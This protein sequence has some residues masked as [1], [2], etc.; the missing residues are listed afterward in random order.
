LEIIIFVILNREAIAMLGFIFILL[1]LLGIWAFMLASSNIQEIKEHWNE[2]RCKMGVM[3][4][5][6]FY[7]HNT[8]EN[9]NYC[10]KNIFT[11]ESGPLLS[12][13]LQILAT[14]IGTISIFVSTLNS[15]RVQFATLLGGINTIFQNFSDRMKQLTYHI[16]V[17]AMRM[18][19]LMKRLYGTFNAMMFMTISGITAMTNF[20]DTFL[21]K[22][23]DT[24]CF[25]PDTPIYVEGKGEIPISEVKMGDTLEGGGKVTSLFRFHA[26]G[27][28]MVILNNILVSTNH[29]V[30]DGTHWVKAE[31][32][33]DA[34][35]AAPWAGGNERPL[36]CLNTSDHRIPLGGYVFLDYD[37][38]EE[39]DQTTMAWIE[40]VINGT[41]STGEVNNISY[42]NS[43]AKNTR[44]KMADGTVKPIHL[45]ELGD[46]VSTGRVI[47]IVRKVIDD[48]CVLEKN[49]VIGAG[50]LVWFEDKW[51]RAGSIYPIRHMKEP[52]ECISLI[53]TP[54]AVLET[55][56]GL[57]F[58]DYMELHSPEAEKDYDPLIRA[59]VL[60]A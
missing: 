10:M 21:F 13:V 59:Q 41:I 40:D 4:F 9:F 32:H 24:F 55:E 46:K 3:P 43:V 42:S 2:N 20:G 12:P 11:A 7:G 18:N 6:S 5:A 51:C 17:S 60:E 33:P 49:T 53:L 14:M 30:Q 31:E 19:S 37:E 15:I 52:L 35:Q 27:Q 16:R 8:A 47:G 22:F 50:L 45:I 34:K 54:S 48:V 39:G 1:A 25:D 28:P 26:D 23:L 57:F 38:T 36:I 29:F 44:I 58:R 56:H